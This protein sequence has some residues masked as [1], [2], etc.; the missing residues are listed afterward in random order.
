PTWGPLRGRAAPGVS[1]RVVLHP[2]V[3]EGVPGGVDHVTVLIGTEPVQLFGVLESVGEV[4]SRLA[5]SHDV[6]PG[7]PAGQVTGRWMTERHIDEVR[8]LPD[9]E[10][11]LTGR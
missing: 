10:R 9:L 3:G 7:E 5:S 1:D 2:G 4:D 8:L 11:Q 6:V